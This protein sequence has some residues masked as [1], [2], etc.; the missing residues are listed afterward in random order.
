MLALNPIRSHRF[1]D[2]FTLMFCCRGATIGSRLDGEA[3]VKNHVDFANKNHPQ[4]YD[5]LMLV[6]SDDEEVRLENHGQWDPT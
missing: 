2:I 3:M 1:V 4:V 6:D 5:E